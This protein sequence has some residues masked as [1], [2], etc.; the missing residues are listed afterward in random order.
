MRLIPGKSKVETEIFK[1]ISEVL[2]DINANTSST[3]NVSSEIVIKENGDYRF[4]HS[5]AKIKRTQPPRKD[6]D[7]GLREAEEEFKNYSDFLSYQIKDGMDKGV[8]FTKANDLQKK[9]LAKDYA[10]VANAQKTKILP[11]EEFYLYISR[12]SRS[13]LSRDLI[14]NS[15]VAK[16]VANGIL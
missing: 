8:D 16:F 11:K 10:T 6:Y 9:E 13:P 12:H 2:T 4:F 7:Y 5:L 15:A 1:G 3:V 14:N